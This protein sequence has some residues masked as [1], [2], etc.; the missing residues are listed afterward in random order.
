MLEDGRRPVLVDVIA[1]HG[2]VAIELF[3]GRAAPAAE[4]AEIAVHG[5]RIS[6][7]HEEQ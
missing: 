7:N 5:I 4:W 2:L 3:H 6:T 1:A